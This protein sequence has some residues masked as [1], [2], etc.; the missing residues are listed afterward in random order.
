MDIETALYQHARGAAG[1]Q[2]LDTY[3]NSEN[4][5]ILTIKMVDGSRA[6]FI[7]IADTLVPWRPPTQ[8]VVAPGFD[9]HRGMG[10]SA[11]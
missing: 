3:I 4:R 9:A 7:A 1:D 5:P 2:N 8:R 11:T 6:E 10:D